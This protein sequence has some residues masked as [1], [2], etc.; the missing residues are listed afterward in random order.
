MKIY[1]IYLRKLSLL[2]TKRIG[3]R[4]IWIGRENVS[5][6]PDFLY[7]NKLSYTWNIDESTKTYEKITGKAKLN[8]QWIR[9]ENW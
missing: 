1:Y 8:Y 5:R 9:W 7:V 6:Q 4:L 2:S 3:R